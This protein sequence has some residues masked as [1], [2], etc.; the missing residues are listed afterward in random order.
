MSVCLNPRGGHLVSPA[1]PTT[2]ICP[3]RGCGFLLHGAII[4]NWQ[5]IRFVQ[6]GPAADLY[7]ATETR[8]GSSNRVKLLIKVLRLPVIRPLQKVEAYLRQ[9]VSM[10]HVHI[11]PLQGLGWAYPEGSI[12]LLSVFEEHGS[13]QQVLR[14]QLLPPLAIAGFVRQ[15]AEALQHAHERQIVHGRLKPENCLFVAPATLQVCDFYHGIFAQS[16][17]TGSP[18]IAPEQLL[19]RTEP[20]SDQYALAVITY[21]LLTGRLPFPTTSFRS[22][23]PPQVDMILNRAMSTQPQ[24]RFPSILIFV[25]ALQN[26]LKLGRSGTGALSLPPSTAFPTS[27]PS[28]S[29]D[30]Q[31][32]A[33]QLSPPNELVP[34]CLLPGHTAQATVLRWAPSGVHLA[35][36]GPDQNV[37]LWLMHQAIGTPL[38]ILQGHTDTVLALSWSPDGSLL[39]SAGADAT[40][41]IWDV[42]QFSQPTRED[43]PD[44]LYKMR[45]GWWGHDGAVAALDW[46]PEGGTIA[47]GGAD[48]SIRLWDGEGKLLSSWQA[49]GRGGVSTLA[50]SPDGSLLASGGIDHQ[51]VLWDP[52]SKAR[53]LVCDEHTDEIRHLAWSADSRW[54]AS[55]AGKKDLRVCVWDAQSGQ[56]LAVFTHHREVVGVF[57]SPSSTWLATATGDGQLQF[58]S[59]NQT[60]PK[61]I[62]RPLELKMPPLSLA[63]VPQS[64]LI[65]LGLSDMMIQVLRF[66]S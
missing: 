62:G 64:G 20:A 52:L 57:W 16:D 39:A 26:A 7:L 35:S 23:L 41:R 9:V 47:S 37:R 14:K 19:N 13:L 63:A 29:S 15:I 17:Y 60:S 6:Q 43:R 22:D 59:T 25:L 46:L 1:A 54:I 4:G 11:H 45:A 65:A 38:T 31:A 18:Y 40:L 58:W 44:A 36:A 3:E 51:L 53:I 48:R 30:R 32:G 55:V 5:V 49:H 10:N 28:P 27:S 56:R 34:L 21:Q 50:W 2:L 66:S 33:V 12:Y 61:Q 24:N 8:Q 42:S